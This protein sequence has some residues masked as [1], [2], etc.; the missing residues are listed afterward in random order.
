MA[1]L[2]ESVAADIHPAISDIP[3]LVR[4]SL[5]HHISSLGLGYRDASKGITRATL[6]H[7][8]A[9]PQLT[10]FSIWTSS[11]AA[12]T[13]LLQG[14]SATTVVEL[15]RAALPTTLRSFSFVTSMEDGTP[16]AAFER[17]GGIYLTVAAHMPQ[18]TELDI[19]HEAS[20]VNMRLDALGALPQ[21]R[22]LSL[23]GHGFEVPLSRLQAVSQLRALMLEQVELDDLVSMCQPPHSLQLETL[24][25]TDTD[26]DEVSMRALVRLPTLTK[27]D[28]QSLLPGLPRLR[29]LGVEECNYLNGAQASSFS[30]ALSRCTAL[31][32]LTF[33]LDF[34]LD[35]GEVPP[36]EEQRTRWTTLLRSLPN[37]VRLRVDILNT[38]PL[39]ALLPLHLPRL[40]RLL[41]HSGDS[42]DAVLAQLAHPTLLEFELMGEHALTEE[43]VQSLLH[44][45]RLPR[46]VKCMSSA[47]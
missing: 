45:P 10:D 20:W 39:L 44:N 16:S 19:D 41:L 18:L 23:N 31:A 22:K 11:N 33:S 24:I 3:S 38:A 8:R 42:N 26:L 36:E 4:S 5:N 46:L 7:L 47:F 25:G 30:E 15:L 32:D 40:E 29:Q 43:E 21:L 12:A 6:H 27:L 28:M 2:G 35:D 34:I 9:L 37:L 13:L 14:T 1:W 17:L